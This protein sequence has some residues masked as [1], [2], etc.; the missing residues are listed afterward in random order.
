MVRRGW[1][2]RGGGSARRRAVWSGVIAAA[3]LASAPALAEPVSTPEIEAERERAQAVLA[4]IEQ[5][6][7]ELELAIDA[8][9][10]ATHRLT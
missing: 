8:Y 4:E 10:G 1:R 2:Q 6:D 5:I 3:A 7:S 9:N